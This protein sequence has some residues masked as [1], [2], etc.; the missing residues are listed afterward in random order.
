[1]S[2]LYF[3]ISC[4]LV[5]S[6]N[7]IGQQNCLD[8]DG[9]N[10]YVATT[11]DAD[12]DVMSTTTWEAW[13]NPQA[14]TDWGFI[15]G[16]EDGGW[17]RFIGI[18]GGKLRVGMSTNYWEVASITYSRW[19]HIAL[20]YKPGSMICYIDGVKYENLTDEGAHLSAGGF[21]IGASQGGAGLFYKGQIDEVRVWNDERTEAEILANMCGLPSYAS[22]TNLVAYYKFDQASGSTNLTDLKGSNIGA[23]TNMNAANDWVSGTCRNMNY[24]SST[25]S[26]AS[27]SSVEK[28]LGN[29]E[30][31]K[32]EVVTQDALTP[33]TLTQI[34]ANTAGSISLSDITNIEVFYTGT[35]NAFSISTSFGS[36][37]PAAGSININGSQVLSEGTNYFWLT[38][39]ANTYGTTGN[40]LDAQITAFTESSGTRTPSVT[41]PAGSRSLADCSS[42]LQNSLDFDGTN[43]YVSIP[44]VPTPAGAFTIEWYLYPNSHS[45]WN[46]YMGAAATDWGGFRFHTTTAGEIY[47]GTDVSTRM[48][49][50]ELPAGTVTLN[51]WQ[52][53]AFTYDA[54]IGR[55]YKDGVLLATKSGMGAPGSWGGFNIGATN[56]NT[57]DGKVDEVRIWNEARTLAEI[58]ANMCDLSSYASEANL[59]AYYKFDQGSGSSRVIDLKGSHNGALT[60]M[61]PATDWVDGS[62]RVMSYVSSTV[63][64]ASTA[65]VQKCLGNHEILKLEVVTQDLPT[66]LTLTQIVANTTGSTSISDITNI[67]VFYTGTT[68]SFSMSNSF[69][70]AIPAVGSI[71]IDGSQI[72]AE[73]TNYFWLTYDIVS[74]AAN[75]RIL[76]A[77]ITGF[78][79]SS[80]TRTPSNTNPSGSRSVVDCSSPSPGG[81]AADLKGWYTP[82]HPLG[83][84]YYS[85]N[86]QNTN[87]GSVDTWRDLSSGDNHMINSGAASTMPIYKSAVED[88]NYNPTLYFNLDD[89][90][91]SSS[92]LSANSN[93]SVYISARSTTTADQRILIGFGDNAGENSSSPRIY[94]CGGTYKIENINDGPSS[95]D[96]EI[97]LRGY[98]LQTYVFGSKWQNGENG[99]S[100]I[101]DGVV[102]TFAEPDIKD[103][104]STFYLG[105]PDAITAFNFGWVGYINEV[106]IYTEQHTVEQ[107]RKIES[108]LAIKYGSTLGVNGTS[109]DY[110]N[111]SNDVIW[112]QTANSGYNYDVTGI[113]RDEASSLDQRKSHTTNRQTGTGK[114]LDILTVANGTNFTSPTAFSSANESFIWGHN[115]GS[116]SAGSAIEYETDNS[117]TITNLLNRRWKVQENG[118][119]GTVT[120]EFNLVDVS[121]V[122]V[123]SKAGTYDDI[124]LIVDEDGDF[125]DGATAITYSSLDNANDKVQFQVDFQSGSG[126]NKGF[127]FTLGTAKESTLPI[128]LLSFD[129]QTNECENTILW[130]TASEANSEEFKLERSYDAAQ[131]ET[132]AEIDAAGFSNSQLN[133]SATDKKLDKNGL[134][135]YRLCETDI[136]DSKE[137]F[138]IKSIN[139]QCETHYLPIIFQNIENREIIVKSQQNGIAYIF[140]QNGKIVLTG[141]INSGNNSL[142]IDQLSPGI[143]F[144][145]VITDIGTKTNRKLVIL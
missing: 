2:K 69:G 97:N 48:T 95:Q 141:K 30:I 84:F 12:K 139:Y 145:N 13:I 35:T 11:L 37:P 44:T 19:T 86:P 71:N 82:T 52:H 118:G 39:D 8:F 49:P 1:M 125:S 132:V 10:D 43:D 25:V 62:C 133:Y 93:G 66:P 79:E 32:L 113:Q 22:E 4:C 23:L 111:S 50:T 124:Y 40:T 90:F 21:T 142:F 94:D 77:Q 76:D 74:N 107:A 116:L 60:N 63:T 20:V 123:V 73:G 27:T 34:V 119:T 7:S 75:G 144:V 127:F 59:V 104:G 112:R 14:P 102:K 80:G 126:Q 33:L 9:S 121:G 72:L 88:N 65:G 3:L 38:Y 15:M 108:Y 81:E 16:M 134:V 70:S 101:Q 51:S 46:Q 103:I 56:S 31:L 100:I 92:Y 78:T 137:Y 105:G 61:D 26:Q 17:D 83:S 36:A 106:I 109:M 135:Y 117:K 110:T 24:V 140:D 96:F 29:H 47:V 99:M 130:T 131:W 45:E 129:V 138:E 5:L 87:D 42:V 54:G 136:D 89:L 28:C 6:L 53:F 55:F 67:E 58:S 115:N 41:N 128:E 91:T 114:F 122:G 18:N 68:N 98:D 64:Q 143:Y 120:M 85:F 57:I